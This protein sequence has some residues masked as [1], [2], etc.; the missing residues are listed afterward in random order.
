MA[1]TV[2]IA[3]KNIVS[4]ADYDLKMAIFAKV[5]GKSC[6]FN[7]T[8]K[9]WDENTELTEDKIISVVD[10]RYDKELYRMFGN[11]KLTNFSTIKASNCK[12]LKD[13][14]AKRDIIIS[15]SVNES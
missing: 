7:F 8:T 13:I 10:F 14:K 12:N 2:S 3:L 9:S 5:R 11:R 4:I 15:L 6:R 1:T